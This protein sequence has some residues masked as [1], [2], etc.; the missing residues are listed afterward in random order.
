MKFSGIAVLLF[1][2]A[3]PVFSDLEFDKYLI[4]DAISEDVSAYDFKFEF[5][6]TGDAPVEIKDIHS[7]CGCTV[8]TLDEKVFQPGRTGT[9]NGTF[10]SEGKSGLQEVRVILKTD[11]I[12]Q[13]SIDLFLKIDVRK[14]L[15]A[16]PFLAL[17]RVGAPASAKEFV[18]ESDGTV[19]V[20]GIESR[21]ENF[22]V[23]LERLP[24]NKYLIKA[25][26]VSTEKAERTLV[27]ILT[28]KVTPNGESGIPGKDYLV[29]LLIK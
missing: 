8:A 7:S 28:E 2:F 29:H 23:E 10:S 17:W 1:A 5:R 27:K 6:N 11:N 12:G 22:H 13:S 3:A 16:N 26:P 24:G 25:A 9:I 18:L 19:K 14:A 4:E 21:S 15:T 20:T